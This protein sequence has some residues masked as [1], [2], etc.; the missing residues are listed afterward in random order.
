MSKQLTYVDCLFL[1]SLFDQTYK[2]N[3]QKWRLTVQWFGISSL[4]LACMNNSMTC[5]Y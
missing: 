3:E 1:L 4:M 2:L 5:S